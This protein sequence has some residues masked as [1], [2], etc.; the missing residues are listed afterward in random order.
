[1]VC[2]DID[3]KS[4]ENSEEELQSMMDGETEDNA[5]NTNASGMKNNVKS[6]NEDEKKDDNEEKKH[7]YAAIPV[8]ILSGFLGAGKT[9][10][11]RHLLQSD[12][13]KLKIA[14]IVNDMAEINIDGEM[15]RQVQK[16]VI[17]L[18]NGCICCRRPWLRRIH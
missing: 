1:M 9:T 18:Q 6:D 16:E 14:V 2:K 17:T 7:D 8:T 3:D 5:T 13:H 10:L 15:I 12:Q 4:V 11:L